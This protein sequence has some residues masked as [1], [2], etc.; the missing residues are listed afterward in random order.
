MMLDAVNV[1]I[2]SMPDWCTSTKL[3]NSTKVIYVSLGVQDAAHKNQPT[4]LRL[5]AIIPH[6]VQRAKLQ[7]YRRTPTT[8][9]PMMA[10]VSDVA[11]VVFDL[12]CLMT[13]QRQWR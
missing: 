13:M 9:R 7:C 11:L 5:G 8:M 4:T 2:T 6:F 1:F 3:V 10:M 12:T